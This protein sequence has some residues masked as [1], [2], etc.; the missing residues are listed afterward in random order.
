[1]NAQLKYS[2]IIN[3]P[4]HVSTKHP[5]M[6][7]EQKAAQFAPFAALTGFDDDVKE[8]ARLTDRRIEIDDGL[9]EVLNSKLNILNDNI[10]NKPLARFTYFIKD[11]KKDGGKY[12]E[13][14]DN[15]KKINIFDNYILLVNNTKI[16]I[17]DIIDIEVK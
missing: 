13:V 10:K 16:I 6:S 14:E 2:D 5:H 7:R 12:I 11:V 17:S 8:T 9:K 15:V 1:M 3:L 4:H